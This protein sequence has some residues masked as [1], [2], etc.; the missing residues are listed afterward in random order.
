MP[1]DIDAARRSIA[2][3]ATSKQLR[4]YPA[5]L[6]AQL[7]RLVRAH[8]ERTVGSLAIAIDMAP[9]TL[10]RIV[11]GAARAGDVRAGLIVPV[12]V[13]AADE[14]NSLRV[15]GP[16]GIVVEGLDVDGVAELIRALS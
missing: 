14:G 2:A 7:A 8:P 16:H 6:C 13:V 5:E 4:R 15:H 11:A 10:Q 9:K 3:L 1:D 12:R